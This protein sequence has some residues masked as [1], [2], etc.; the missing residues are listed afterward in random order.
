ML[1]GAEKLQLGNPLGGPLFLIFGI[2]LAGWASNLRE[3]VDLKQR[4]SSLEGRSVA[5]SERPSRTDR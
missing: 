3:I 2:A 4:V 5:S 1:P